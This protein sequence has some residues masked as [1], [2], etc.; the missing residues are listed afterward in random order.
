VPRLLR[1][2]LACRRRAGFRAHH[3]LLGP[4][5]QLDN[6]FE[7]LHIEAFAPDFGEDLLLGLGKL[8][9]FG[10]DLLYALHKR[11]GPIT[12]NAHYITHGVSSFVYGSALSSRGASDASIGIDDVL[13][14]LY[15]VS[16]KAFRY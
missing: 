1:P 7:H 2:S 14:S 16:R 6:L 4:V 8:L 5:A 3:V 11:A 15:S 12:C 13:S 9:G 10:L